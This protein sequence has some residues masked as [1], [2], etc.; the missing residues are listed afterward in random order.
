MASDFEKGRISPQRGALGSSSYPNYTGGGQTSQ[1]SYRQFHQHD[2]ATV[3][4]TSQTAPLMGYQNQSQGAHF[5][6]YQNPNPGY[7]QPIPPPAPNYEAN[8]QSAPD[9]YQS[10]DGV[11]KGNF[12][13]KSLVD[14][15]LL[16]FVLGPLGAHHLYLRRPWFALLYFGTL[17]LF[18]WGWLVDMIRLP[19]LV[20]DANF[21]LRYPETAHHRCKMDAYLLW[22]PMGL[23]GFHLF[24]L[25]KPGQGM[26][27]F[28]T[29]GLFGIG[30]LVDLFRIPSIVRECN[31][32]PPDYDAD[33]SLFTAYMFWMP[34]FG[35]YGS[36]H[37]YLRRPMWGLLY[38]FTWGLLGFGWLVDAFR[39]PVLTK[40]AN[41]EKRGEKDKNERHLDDAYLL[42][43]PF[44]ITGLHH[45]YLGRIGWG[46]LYFFTFGLALIGWLIDMC[47][48]P[49][50][51]REHNLNLVTRQRLQATRTPRGGDGA[52]G[53]GEMGPGVMAYPSAPPLQSSYPETSYLRPPSYAQ[54][55][56]FGQQGYGSDNPPTY[57]ESVGA[58]TV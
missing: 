2:G 21:K 33:R 7:G 18:G 16:C 27:Y 24:Y 22:F 28:F 34:P 55:G 42:W 57:E 45:F 39:L 35:V 4:T 53:G 3:D 32:L 10:P 20:R 13:Q 50:L 43:F 54:P 23:L 6:G 17:G 38:F 12:P 56:A 1:S 19:C 58:R 9:P 14:A 29:L 44:G 30:W 52:G 47:R 36:H 11:T 48:L 41:L 46:V 31:E 40:R 5:T 37:F 25:R 49:Y 15:Y 26:L 51:V 8:G